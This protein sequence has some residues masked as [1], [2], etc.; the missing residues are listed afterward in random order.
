MM[1][2]MDMFFSLRLK[3][4]IGI[5]GFDRLS[6]ERVFYLLKKVHRH[7]YDRCRDK[8]HIHARSSCYFSASAI[9]EYGVYCKCGRRKPEGASR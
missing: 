6:I 2:K 8:G 1:L 3:R 4:F 5:W 9:K 7:R